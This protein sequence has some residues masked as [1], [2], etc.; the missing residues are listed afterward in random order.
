M[1]VFLNEVML[2]PRKTAERGTNLVHWSVFE[3]GG[4]FA[5]AEEPELVIEDVRKCFRGLR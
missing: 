4:H 1:A 2:M 3:S 5:P